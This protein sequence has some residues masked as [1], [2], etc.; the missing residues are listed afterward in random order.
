[1]KYKTRLTESKTKLISQQVFDN[2]PQSLMG[3]VEELNKVEN[4]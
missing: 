2:Q 3:R 1:V 4:E